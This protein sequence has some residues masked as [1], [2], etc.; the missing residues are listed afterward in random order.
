[1]ECI[2]NFVGNSIVTK[3]DISKYDVKIMI[4]FYCK[5]TITYTFMRNQ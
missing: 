4:L 2:Q 3:I 5:F 1:M